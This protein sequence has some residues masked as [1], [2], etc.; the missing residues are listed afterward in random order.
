MPGFRFAAEAG[1]SFS[2][3]SLALLKDIFFGPVELE[4]MSPSWDIIKTQMDRRRKK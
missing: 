3:L 4:Q 2:L 1:A